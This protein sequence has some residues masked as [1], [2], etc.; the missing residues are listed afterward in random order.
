MNQNHKE[1]I[2]MSLSVF[3]VFFSLYII[4]RFIPSLVWATIVV[5]T[6][7]PLYLRW[8]KLLKSRDN[9]AAFLFT[10]FLALL[11]LLPLSWLLSVLV[12][13][14]QLFLTYVKQI[15]RLGG[16]APSFFQELPMIGDN[17]VAYWDEHIGQPGNVKSFLSNLHISLTP[18]SYYIKE[19]GGS[20]FHR[21]VQ[22]GF[23]LLSMFFLYRDGHILDKQLNHVGHALLGERWYRFSSKLPAALRATVNGTIVVG[24][25][26]GILMG[27]CYGLIGVPAP[28]LLGIFT[29][30]A[31][32]IPFVVPLVFGIVA[33]I[34]LHHGAMISAVI[35]IIWGTVV[36]FVADH[37]IKPLLIGGATQLPFL[38]VLFGILGGLETMGILGLFVGPM[39]MVLF[40]TLWNEAQTPVK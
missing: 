27:I 35:V 29:A 12:K 36:M 9:L 33:L 38:A 17:M 39:V 40:V 5:I 16:E 30:F 26:V 13:E 3:I 22:V 34:L 11:L 4:H 6:T 7:Y 15:N 1:L 21:G 28:T 14:F 20:V 24:V 19:V 37:F 18:T 2:S 23:T 8:K 10:S 25:G 32:M 31:A